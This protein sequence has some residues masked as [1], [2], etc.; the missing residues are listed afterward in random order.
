MASSYFARLK[1]DSAETVID[2]F[3]DTLIDTK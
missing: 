3:Y 2:K 1:V